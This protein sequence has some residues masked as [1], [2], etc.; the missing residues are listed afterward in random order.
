MRLSQLNENYRGQP[1]PD[2]EGLSEDSRRIEEGW[3]FAAFPGSKTDGR[4]YVEDA[5]RNGA[6]AIL[7]AS[8][9]DIVR[10]P[11]VAVIEDGNPRRCLAQMAARFYGRQPRHVAT[12]TGTN[13]KT[14]TAWFTQQIWENLGI[15]AA[16]LGTLGI[17]GLEIAAMKD[18]RASSMTTP[19][20]VSLMATL[21]DLSA[22]GID[23]LAME[24]SSHGLSQYRLDGVRVQAAAFTNLTR[25]HLDYHP[26]MDDY[27]AAKARLFR[28]VLAADGVA[29]LNADIPQYAVLR[30]ICDERGV[31]VIDYGRQAQALILRSC[32]T[33]A[34]GQAL[35]IGWQGKLYELKLPLV[36]EFMVMN[37]LAALGLVLAIDP[38]RA[39]RAIL[40]LE[41]LKGA[42]GRL[43]LVPGHPHGAVYV[44]YAH[45]PDA[46][47]NILKALRPHTQGRLICVVGCGGDR[48]PG[49]RPIMGRLAFTLA[50]VAVITDDNPRSENPE[51]IRAAM[52]A[53][54][55]GAQEIG[56][57]RAAIG[58][59]VAHMQAGDVLVVAGK[60]HEQGQIVAGRVEPFD[61]VAEAAQAIRNLKQGSIS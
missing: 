50:D 46:L 3:L 7:C 59:A 38:E 31:K 32:E 23:H 40:A 14:S 28:E 30:A 39:E 22:S 57:R 43:Q 6:T 61:D 45:T 9:R 8:A 15:K 51:K 53:E 35:A 13:G 44:D 18:T 17:R 56:D 54:A 55:P 25:D 41:R 27:F 2:I 16:S 60:G 34:D 11:D 33:H 36:G 47:E 49:K 12:V 42:P 52:M 4:R 19:D 1:D 20:I 5:M 29:V 37:A 21:A 26:D 58:W 10:P 24:A 48:D